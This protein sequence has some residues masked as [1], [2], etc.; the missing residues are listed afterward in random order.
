MK[1]IIVEIIKI[2]ILLLGVFYVMNYVFDDKTKDIQKKLDKIESN[3]KQIDSIFTIVD[4]IKAQR[5]V[6]INNIGKRDDVI[7]KQKDNLKKPLP[8]DTNI[9]NAIKFLHDYGK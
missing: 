5:A 7:N 3:S 9:N 4:T 6:I 1:D 2:G 8:K